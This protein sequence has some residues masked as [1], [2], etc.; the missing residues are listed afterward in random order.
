MGFIRFVRRQ[1]GLEKFY[2]IKTRFGYLGNYS[3]Y[4][5]LLQTQ[6]FC[7]TRKDVLLRP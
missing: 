7:C 2:S 4:P 6:I 1:K 3:P 5:S